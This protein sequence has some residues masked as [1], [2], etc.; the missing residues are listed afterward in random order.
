M[1]QLLCPIDFSSTANNAVEYAAALSKHIGAS[2]NLFHFLPLPTLQEAAEM[3]AG[4]HPDTESREAKAKEKMQVYCDA[5]KENFSVSC[6]SVVRSSPSELERA[7]KKE[8]ENNRYDLLVMGTDGADNLQQLL[9]GTN[10]NHVLRAVDCSVL[11]VPVTSPW[12]LPRKI[13]YATDYEK[14]DTK[15]LHD[16][17]EFT[18][19][20]PQITILH[21]NQN[22]PAD[23]NELLRHFKD[24]LQGDQDNTQIHF[25]QLIEKDVFIAIDDYMNKQE[26]DLLVLLWKNYTFPEKLFHRSTAGKM[27]NIATYPVLVWKH[28]R[29]R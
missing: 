9:F 13:V 26:A 15:A 22:S 5:I 27:S 8:V 20:S 6:R 24:T 3:Q 14:E 7:L 10:T 1:K 18:G 21:V 4:F 12:R 19:K 23:S 16:A 25:E 11:V 28:A 29:S 2:L 17:L